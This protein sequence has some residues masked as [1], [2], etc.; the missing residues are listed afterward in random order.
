MTIRMLRLYSATSELCPRLKPSDPTVL[1]GRVRPVQG[2]LRT[3]DRRVGERRLLR[4]RVLQ[5]EFCG[6][7]GRSAAGAALGP[8][9]A[10]P[11]A[12]RR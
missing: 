4:R 10:T 12:T 3:P 5:R 9:A 6:S 1:C 8:G 11:E 2:D 7:G